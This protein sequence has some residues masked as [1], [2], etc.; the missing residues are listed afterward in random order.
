[1]TN[2]I[3]Q[4]NVFRT[5]QERCHTVLGHRIER[6]R[7]LR[8]NDSDTDKTRLE[9]VRK[10]NPGFVDLLLQSSKKQKGLVKP[11][12]DYNDN[13]LIDVKNLGDAFPQCSFKAGWIVTPTSEA[14]RSARAARL[15]IRQTIDYEHPAIVAREQGHLMG[16]IP[17]NII[18]IAFRHDNMLQHNYEPDDSGNSLFQ[19]CRAIPNGV[20]QYASHGEPLE[21]RFYVLGSA[22]G[23]RRESFQ[24][25]ME[26][27]RTVRDEALKEKLE[28]ALLINFMRRFGKSQK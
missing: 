20:V 24:S 3:N 22:E 26:N 4:E 1:M 7:I 19:F 11:E 23:S 18:A 10:E 21:S 14:L 17:G 12:T 28:D 13:D 9:L 27:P 6:Y 16:L 2:E 5:D 8:I 15:D 25:I